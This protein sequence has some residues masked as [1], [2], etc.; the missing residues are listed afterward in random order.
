MTKKPRER[1]LRRERERAAEKL[2]RDRDKLA[3]LEAGGSPERPTLLESASQVEVHARALPC[4][5]C[6]G[7]LRVDEHVAREVGGRRLRLVR[8]VCPACGTR[9]DAWFQLAPSLPS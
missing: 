2:A 5:R 1:T 7:E 9:R 8:L 6:G 4:V 3:R